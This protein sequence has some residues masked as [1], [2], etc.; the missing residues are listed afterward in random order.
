MPESAL[1]LVDLDLRLARC[2][3]VVAEHQHFGRAAEVL[4]LTPS[5]LSRQIG[6]LERDVGARLLDPTPPGRRPTAAR[7]GARA[8][9]AAQ[10][11]RITV[12]YIANIAV[13]AV[14]RD[15]RH[16]HPDADV[17]TLHLN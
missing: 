6:R 2:F 17:R 8:R 7:A 9:A 5:S 1:P 4:H 14:V 13:T 11:S 15:L 12:G 16:R 10:P 3:V